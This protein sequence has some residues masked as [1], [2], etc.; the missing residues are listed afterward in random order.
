MLHELIFNILILNS[1]R[2]EALT[3]ERPLERSQ[4][5]CSVG[6]QA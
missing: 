4:N 5:P 2:T 1:K 3:I 6:A